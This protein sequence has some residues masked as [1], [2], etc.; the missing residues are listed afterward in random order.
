MKHG[1]GNYWDMIA[2]LSNHFYFQYKGTTKS[3]IY[4]NGNVRAIQHFDA[5]NG[6]LYTQNAFVGVSA[7][8]NVFACFAY[9]GYQDGAGRYAMLQDN[10]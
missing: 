5:P 1:N 4:D 3:I 10:V 8:G 6:N 7:Y 2:P 9:K